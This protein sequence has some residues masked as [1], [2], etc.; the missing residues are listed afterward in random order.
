M[1]PKKY[2]IRSTVHT[3]PHLYYSNSASGYVNFDESDEFSQK[4]RDTLQLPPDGEWIEV[5]KKEEE[6]EN[7]NDETL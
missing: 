7:E 4:E 5:H 6:L 1:R 2:K 3:E